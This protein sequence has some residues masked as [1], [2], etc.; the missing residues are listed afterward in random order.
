MSN[1][2]NDGYF[3][4]LRNAIRELWSDTA[5]VTTSETYKDAHNITQSRPVILFEN[6]PCKVLLN[7]QDDSGSGVHGVDTY[8]VK[9]LIRTGLDIPAGAT[10]EVTDQNGIKT[11]YRRASKGYSGYRSHQVFKLK[12]DEVA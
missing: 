12:R 6:E 8:D 5:T 9:I 2:F 1:Y 10:V 11:V 4:P 3:E 7:K